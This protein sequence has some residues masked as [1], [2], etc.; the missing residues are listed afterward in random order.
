MSQESKW[1]KKFRLFTLILILSGGLNIF[2]LIYIIYGHF[3]LHPIDLKISPLKAQQK[4]KD[5][6]NCDYLSI[7]ST[8][9]FS[10]LVSLLSNCQL[11]EEGYSKRDLALG[12]LISYHD[13]N[14]E[15]ALPNQNF[16]TRI[17]HYKN[18]K[19][20]DKEVVLI[21]GL[22]DHHYKSIIHYAFSEKWP[23]TSKGLFFLLKKWEKPRDGSLEKAFFVTE[24]FYNI[25]NLF[26][27]DVT[28]KQ[29][30]VLDLICEC[31]SWDYIEKFS[32]EQKNFANRDIRECRLQFL[33]HAL[34]DKSPTAA[35]LLLRSDFIY[36]LKRL[37]DEKILDI[38]SLLK[39]QS[40]ELE[41]FCVELLKSSRSDDIWRAA[42]AKLYEFSK[43]N[44]PDNLIKA[45]VKKKFVQSEDLKNKWQKEESKP[46]S[47]RNIIRGA[48]KQK[49]NIH[50]VREG[51]NLWKIARL[52]KVEIDELI[53]VNK[54]ETERIFPGLEII[55]PK[56][57]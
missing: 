24:E 37:S 7:I 10:E 31:A 2:F 49:K 46:G 52:Y 47:L 16:Q 40:K 20:E 41:Q 19:K 43:E 35:Y 57:R 33:L 32:E 26:N 53:R 51:E 48:D 13:F 6:N 44:I 30:E 25:S 22:R 29:I 5:L 54:L 4:R 56:T 45:E 8:R 28:V 3:A 21:P 15:K 39:D 50:I 12:C 18:S 9:N 17:V 36:A 42:A 27:Q 38:L 11:V 14:L 23:L 34:G 1:I 55:I